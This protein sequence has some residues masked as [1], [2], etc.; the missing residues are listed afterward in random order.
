MSVTSG[1]LTPSITNSGST[2]R[3]NQPCNGYLELCT[4]SFGNITY[5]AAHNSPFVRPNNVVV[6]QNVEVAQQLGDGVRTCK[7]GEI[8]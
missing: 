2:D 5:V 3:T 4:R 6:F 8:H 1:A 7:F